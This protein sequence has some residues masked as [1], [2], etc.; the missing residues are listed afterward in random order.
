[1]ELGHLALGILAAWT[2]LYLVMNE[3]LSPFEQFKFEGT[4]LQCGLRKMVFYILL[5]RNC[6]ML[7]LL[8]AALQRGFFDI[9]SDQEL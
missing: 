9:N 1:M 3:I 8:F 7:L 4:Y 5:I 2:T 6:C